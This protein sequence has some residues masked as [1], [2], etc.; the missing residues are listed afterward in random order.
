[1]K[2]NRIRLHKYLRDY[3]HARNNYDYSNPEIARNI[4][5]YGVRLDG[6]LTQSR[7]AWV[8]PGQ[9]LTFDWPERNHGDFSR[10][11][12]LETTEKYLLLYKPSGVV[13][14]PGAGH[15]KD[16][17]VTWLLENYPEQAA[18]D[19]ETYP[20]RGL[21]HRLDKLTQGLLLVARDEAT[22]QFFQDQFRARQVEKKY[23]AVLSGVL[24]ETFEIKNY[25]ARSQNNPT[26]NKLFW[27][28][29]EA[30]TYDEK[31]RFAHSAFTPLFVSRETDRTLAE[32]KIMTGRTHQIRLQAQALGHA[33]V[34]DG[35]YPRVQSSIPKS[36]WQMSTEFDTGLRRMET[37]DLHH[38]NGEEFGELQVSIFGATEFCL[39]S[40]CLALE[41][42]D[43]SPL[44]RQYYDY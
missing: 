32:V 39:L 42:P 44:R 28:A 25:Q 22:L 1:M 8:I 37:S 33:L 26:K 30:L 10:V 35:K 2:K 24:T 12:V 29:K 36:A 7:L 43:G 23:L 14:Q 31:A 21:V 4:E 41:A 20:T 5:A 34:A 17:L 15:E 27:S 19:P 16:N 38:I 3:L 11:K 6:V 9:E 40:N 13:V 18:F